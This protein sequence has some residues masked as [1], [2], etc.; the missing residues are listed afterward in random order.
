M[1][2]DILK[3]LFQTLLLVPEQHYVWARSSRAASAAFPAICTIRAVVQP[4]ARAGDSPA[5]DFQKFSLMKPEALVAFEAQP[6]SLPQ[7]SEWVS[8][9]SR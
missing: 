2:A 5:Y 1:V 6:L 7:V 4:G 8:V 3:S 9:G